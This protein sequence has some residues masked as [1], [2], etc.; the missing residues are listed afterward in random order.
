MFPTELMKQTYES[1][2]R[3]AERGEQ[4][5]SGGALSGLAEMLSQL[6]HVAVRHV[7]HGSWTATSG[8][9]IPRILVAVEDPYM[10]VLLGRSIQR[11]GT[12][13]MTR[14]EW[15][16]RHVG[17]DEHPWINCIKGFEYPDGWASDLWWIHPLNDPTDQTGQNEWLADAHSDYE[18]GEVLCAYIR[19]MLE[20]EL[21]LRA[22]DDALKL[23]KRRRTSVA[24]RKR[25]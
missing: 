12:H 16:I 1:L 2:A 11:P 10:A 5:W 9:T 22:E 8:L 14:L 23:R 21:A 6:P 24:E 19:I 13:A 20:G 7:E 25:S 3:P 4:T 17:D 15:I 18:T